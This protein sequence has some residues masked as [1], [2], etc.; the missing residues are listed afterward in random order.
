MARCCKRC[1]DQFTKIWHWVCASIT[2][3]LMIGVI[4]GF[5]FFSEEEQSHYHEANCN[6]SNCKITVVRTC[7]R[8]S[9]SYACY[10]GSFDYS[11]IVSDITA[12]KSYSFSPYN[13]YNYNSYLICISNGTVWC[14]YDDRDPQG[15][16]TTDY[17]PLSRNLTLVCVAAGSVILMT[18]LFA[19]YYHLER[20]HWCK[21]CNYIRQRPE[22][23]STLSV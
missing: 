19:V 22:A 16:L 5:A 18:I 13:S 8:Y 3:A 23:I 9:V 11:V 10:E 4:I 7:T 21:N 20:L 14:A 17:N 1:R 12:S 6:V 15:T 2:V